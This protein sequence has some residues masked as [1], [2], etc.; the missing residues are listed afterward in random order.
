MKSGKQAVQTT[1]AT[2]AGAGA[3][4]ISGAIK[5]AMGFSSLYPGNKSGTVMGKIFST[6]LNQISNSSNRDDDLLSGS[7]SGAETPN[8][9]QNSNETKE[10]S[11]YISGIPRN[12]TN[13]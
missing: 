8:D 6:T 9:K 4:A 10:D 1:T 5:G 3:G 11:T 2:I 12:D 7:I 13:E